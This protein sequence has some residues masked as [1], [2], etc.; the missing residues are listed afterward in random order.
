M[1]SVVSDLGT[2]EAIERFNDAVER[3]DVGALRAAITEDCVFESPG[4][5]DGKRYVGSSMVGVFAT[6]FALDGEGPFEVEEMF[7]AGDRA[8]VRWSH[9]WEHAD[10][11]H[12]H[13]RGV[14]LFLVRDG[15]VAEK[16]SYVK[17]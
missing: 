1:T 16:L 11:E 17:G 2:R 7:T 3:K 13:V 9:P 4:A 12:G 8:V 10:G 15:R 6:F 14:D 5:P